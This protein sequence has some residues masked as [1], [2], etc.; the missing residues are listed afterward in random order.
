MTKYPLVFVSGIRSLFFYEKLGAELQ[1]FIKAHGYVVLYPI[2]PFRARALRKQVFRQW[3]DRQECKQF[4]FVLSQNTAKEFADLLKQYP[5]STLTLT[6]TLRNISENPATETFSYK[7]HRLFC[8]VLGLKVD[9][10]EATLP[11]KTLEFYDRFL[12]RCVELAENEVL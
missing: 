10:F 11:I 7:L 4:H 1:V 8:A 6:D 2:I 5:D 9:S 3:L 12:D